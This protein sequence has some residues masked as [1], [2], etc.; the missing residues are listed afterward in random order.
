MEHISITRTGIGALAQWEVYYK[1]DLVGVG[2]DEQERPS[3][4]A[5]V[6]L[7]ERF[8]ADLAAGNVPAHYQE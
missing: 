4:P 3:Y 7:A 2:M 6:A 1:G 5:A 8:L